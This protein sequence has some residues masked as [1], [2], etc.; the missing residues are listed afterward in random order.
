MLRRVELRSESHYVESIPLNSFEQ[1]IDENIL[2]RGLNYFLKGHV[3]EFEEVETGHYKALVDGTEDYAVSLRVEKNALIHY[4]CTCP[5]DQGPICKH[6]VASIF[7]L[8]ED[9]LELEPKSKK[10]TS[11]PKS[12]KT[13][14]RKTQAEKLDELLDKL[15]PEELKAI[16]KRIADNDS[17][18]RKILLASY[19]HHFEKE[20]KALYTKQIKA[21]LQSLKDSRRFVDYRAAQVAGVHVYAM[22]QTAQS[23]M[24]K[25][26]FES[27]LLISC[28]V[29]E[30]M[31]K[32]LDFADDSNGDIGM[33]INY[34]VSILEALAERDLP[35]PFRKQMFN[36]LTEAYKEKL[37]KGWDWHLEMLEIAALIMQDESETD[38]I[39]EQLDKIKKEDEF[40]YNYS[41]AQL[42]KAEILRKTKGESAALAYIE[43]NLSNPGLREV[44]LQTAYAEQNF[45]KAI[46]IA[47][48]GIKH[49]KGNKPG[50]VYQWVDWLLRIAVAQNNT[51]KII[52][53]A[54]KLIIESNADSKVYYEVLKNTVDASQWPAFMEKLIFDI[55]NKSVW[56]NSTLIANIYANEGEWDKLLAFLKELVATKRAS[57]TLID[58]FSSLFPGQYSG[59]LADIYQDLISD[60]L[61]KN[62]NRNYYR[63]ACKYIKGIIK[64]GES[65]KAT[66]FIQNLKSKYANRPALIE[67]LNKIKI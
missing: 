50:L 15:P 66:E 35:E 10:A 65:Q 41:K 34:A 3:G 62:A 55:R 26:N 31:T 42:I 60:F 30:E 56:F 32:A 47:Q 29:L 12:Q 67:E 1:Y 51:E 20:S 38:L 17:S 7:H 58:S 49:D 5:Y 36:Y 57:L 48:D 6:V 18:F 44:A 46:S 37:F 54:R 33:N 53:Y 52:E 28:A 8:Q 25:G 11:K 9:V 61:S 21:L 59:E 13:S 22:M 24:D 23:Q 14:K 45:E 16:V 4:S 64:L 2:Q 39:L 27:A 43:K 19:A 63:E 40:G